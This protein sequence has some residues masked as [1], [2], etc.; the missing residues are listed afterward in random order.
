MLSN[1]QR[2][3]VGR[4]DQEQVE[5]QAK[6]RE[7]LKIQYGTKHEDGSDSSDAISRPS[8]A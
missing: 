5:Y 4:R 1:L 6:T 2:R 7:P 3:A 8:Q